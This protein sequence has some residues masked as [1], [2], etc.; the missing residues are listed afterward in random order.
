MF[1]ELISARETNSDVLADSLCIGRGKMLFPHTYISQR[2][3]SWNNHSSHPCCSLCSAIELVVF[4]G[5][6]WGAD[7]QEQDD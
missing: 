4:D 6:D 7:V 2:Q 3:R 1:A 5:H